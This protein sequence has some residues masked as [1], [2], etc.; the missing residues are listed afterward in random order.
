MDG[1]FQTYKKCLIQPGKRMLIVSTNLVGEFLDATFIFT[2]P[3]HSITAF[4]LL[5]FHLIFKLPYLVGDMKYR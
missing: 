1:W 2:H 5:H 3:L 4:L